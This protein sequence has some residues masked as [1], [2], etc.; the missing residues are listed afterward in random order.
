MMNRDSFEKDADKAFAAAKEWVLEHG[1][2]SQ[3]Q[4]L[5][6]EH[7]VLAAF[8]YYAERGAE[9]PESFPIAYGRVVLSS[10]EAPRWWKDEEPQPLRFDPHAE[11]SSPD[12]TSDRFTLIEDVQIRFTLGLS[13]LSVRDRLK[14]A[15]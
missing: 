6:E 9:E 7:D 13:V 12:E 14:R 2:A 4:L 8:R 5:A 3:P 1:S 11:I 15:G 10:G